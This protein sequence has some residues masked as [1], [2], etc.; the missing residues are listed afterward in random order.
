MMCCEMVVKLKS[1][2]VVCLGEWMFF[3][4]WVVMFAFAFVDKD[5]SVCDLVNDVFVNW[6]VV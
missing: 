3:M 6:V 1:G 2:F 5:K 4:M